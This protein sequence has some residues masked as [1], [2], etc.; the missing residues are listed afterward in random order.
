MAKDAIFP[1]TAGL[2]NAS[3][4]AMGLAGATDEAYDGLSLLTSA[5]LA[6][7][8]AGRA[9]A[10]M[11][12]EVTMAIAKVNADAAKVSPEEIGQGFAGA[13][14]RLESSLVGLSGVA[15]S[16]TIRT[17][18]DQYKA[19]LQ[20]VYQEAGDITD[21]E[22][23][24]REEAVMNRL[25]STVKQF[26][27]AADGEKSAI[28]KMASQYATLRSAVESALQPTAVTAE[29]MGL[30]ATGDYVEKWDENARRLDAIA[31]RGFAELQQH[32]D[33]AAALNIPPEV[34]A[35]SEQALKAWANRTAD[36]VRNLTRPD[37]IDIGAAADAVQKTLQDKAAKEITVDLV[38]AELVRRGGVS[39][40]AARQQ[41][42][43]M[44]GLEEPLPVSMQLTDTAKAD[45]ITAVGTVAVPATLDLTTTE[46]AEAVPGEAT[47][48]LVGQTLPVS[49][50][51]VEGGM[52]AF[53]LAVGTIPLPVSFSVAGAG[54]EGEE[55]DMTAVV[56]PVVAALVVGFNDALDEFSPALVLAERIVVD[57]SEQAKVL[58]DAGGTIWDGVEK[59]LI[60]GIKE[61]DYADEFA[62]V[63]VPVILKA[64]KAWGEYT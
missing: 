42:L 13:T 2:Q 20:A 33:W 46:A 34:L 54:G 26:D 43:Q 44:Y 11:M 40:E 18:Y 19:E 1:A 36:A 37:L 41:A 14:S 60:D 55:A 57:V 24:M 17:L 27:D 61:G 64:I 49:L 50:S 9:Y 39:E 32:A 48:G 25:Q 53:L 52:D 5:F 29:D 51:L 38:V 12:D 3:S 62:R 15:P 31:E 63:L 22:L 28:D 56:Q 58:R 35:S 7:S 8:P 47:G 45:F 10:G 23:K 59:G 4:A 21:F 16:D 6:A 30:A